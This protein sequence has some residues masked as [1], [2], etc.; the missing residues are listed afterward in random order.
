MFRG[1][2]RRETPH[3]VRYVDSDMYL[4]VDEV[5]SVLQISRQGVLDLITAG[6]LPFL[7]L[8]VGSLCR[9]RCCTSSRTVARRNM[10][11]ERCVTM[12]M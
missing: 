12:K 11:C 5:R 9:S 8:P 1:T 6:D 7:S 2:R 4:T 10:R 3:E